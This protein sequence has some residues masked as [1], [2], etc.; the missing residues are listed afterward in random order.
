MYMCICTYTQFFLLV[1]SPFK[2]YIQSWDA[3]IEYIYQ[4]SIF[5]KGG[6]QLLA[7]ALENTEAGI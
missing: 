5:L 7:T 6:C 4:I 1:F 3:Y 2:I